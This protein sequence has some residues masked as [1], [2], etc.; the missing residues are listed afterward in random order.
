MSRAL[1]AALK[2]ADNDEVKQSFAAAEAKFK[3]KLNTRSEKYQNSVLLWAKHQFG[4][5]P[6]KQRVYNN[7]NAW[8]NS[9][10]SPI[11]TSIMGLPEDRSSVDP[12]TSLK[13]AAIFLMEQEIP[14]QANT[15]STEIQVSIE[16]IWARKFK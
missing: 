3:E 2:L 11:V 1:E 16:K 13:M 15:W 4:A 12:E 10:I 6:A 5:H 7:V 9:F 14:E 8:G